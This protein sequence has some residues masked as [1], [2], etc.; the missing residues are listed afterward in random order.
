MVTIKL[1]LNQ[2]TRHRGKPKHTHRCKQKPTKVTTTTP[3]LSTLAGPTSE[4]L[5]GVS[6]IRREEN[7]ARVETSLGRQE[8][9]KGVVPPSLPQAPL[10]INPPPAGSER[11][12]H[13]RSH[14]DA[15]K[16]EERGGR[17]RAGRRRAASRLSLCNKWLGK[18]SDKRESKRVRE[19]EAEE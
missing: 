6:K 13:L 4:E 10:P 8:K 9:E 2:T 19:T 12:K 16:G 17:E 3:P 7:P 18:G 15:V 1:R 5:A 14:S 11:K